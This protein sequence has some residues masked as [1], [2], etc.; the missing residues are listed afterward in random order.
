MIATR[1]KEFFYFIIYR[2]NSSL[3]GWSSL[4]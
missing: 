4:P 1:K 3:T 2:E